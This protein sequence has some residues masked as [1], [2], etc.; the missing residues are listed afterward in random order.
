[1]I[2]TLHITTVEPLAGWPGCEKI[3]YENRLPGTYHERVHLQHRQTVTVKLL[4]RGR[5]RWRIGEAASWH[6][7]D[8]GQALV[9]DA[10]LHGN[11]EYAGDPAGGHLEF[12]YANLTGA[13]MHTAT[14]GILDRAQGH[15]VPIHSAEE[16]IKRWS[17]KLTTNA[18]APAYRCL[19][20][21]EACELAWSFLHPLARGLSPTNQLAERAMAVLTEHWRDPP[22]MSVLAQRLH[23]SREHLARILR[24]TCGQPPG[25]WLRRYRLG[26]AADMLESG[27]SIQ[28]VA[29]A[30]GYCSIP[31]FIH[32]FR[33]ILGTT[34]G[35]WL[36]DKRG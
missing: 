10:G 2:S 26:R 24:S 27:Q 36:R 22:N 31:H 35:R 13:P 33:R 6:S 25:L 32:A 7:V 23:V 9:Y 5:L 18:N 29:E 17:A 14:A 16:L 3:V 28:A 8:P 21:V 12:I 1:M 30:C 20:V 4:M 34:P 19:S 11:L 15:A